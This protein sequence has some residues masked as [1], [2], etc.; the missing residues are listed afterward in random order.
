MVQSISAMWQM[1]FAKKWH[2]LIS[3]RSALPNFVLQLMPSIWRGKLE[4]WQII[5]CLWWVRK[6]Y[7]GVYHLFS[8]QMRGFYHVQLKA[9]DGSMKILKMVTIAIWATNTSERIFL[10]QFP[11]HTLCMFSF[12]VCLYD[13]TLWICF[14]NVN[15]FVL[16]YIGYC[17]SVE[18]SPFEGSDYWLSSIGIRNIFSFDKIGKIQ[19]HSKWSKSCMQ[20][21]HIITNNFKA[22]EETIMQQPMWSW[23][24]SKFP[25]DTL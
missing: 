22:Q 11:V 7:R 15:V 13:A 14:V 20:N 12:F 2:W 21:R 24:P 8:R 1:H 10:N 5:R 18:N 4:C 3:D 6:G 25:G 19:V 9:W 16:A 23:S 17:D